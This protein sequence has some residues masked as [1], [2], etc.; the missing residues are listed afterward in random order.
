VADLNRASAGLALGDKACGP[1]LPEP[2]EAGLR[3][4][5]QA[6]AAQVMAVAQRLPL[7]GVAAGL[8]PGSLGT[9]C[10]LGSG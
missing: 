10:R 9:S 4:T 6:Q 7:M 1:S 5:T 2:T 8:R 3:V